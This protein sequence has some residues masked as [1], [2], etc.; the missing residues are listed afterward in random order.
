MINEITNDG[1]KLINKR[2]I[3]YINGICYNIKLV[4]EAIFFE[5]KTGNRVKRCSCCN[6]RRN[7]RSCNCSFR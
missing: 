3:E 7:D 2:N 4:K 6:R 5:Q 1:M